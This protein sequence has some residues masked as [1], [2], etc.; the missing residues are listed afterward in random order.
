MTEKQK[1]VN[2]DLCGAFGYTSFKG[3]ATTGF[4]TTSWDVCDVTG[5]GDVV[6]IEYVIFIEDVVIFGDVV[7]LTV[8]N[9]FA[10]RHGVPDMT[11]TLGFFLWF[12]TRI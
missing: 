4:L 3:V 6:I 5:R 11:P 7:M 8:G 1:S 9:L 10:S 2:D 12:C